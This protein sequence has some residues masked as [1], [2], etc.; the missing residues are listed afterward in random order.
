MILNDKKLIY[1][2]RVDKLIK[3]KK[4]LYENIDISEPM[5][6]KEKQLNTLISNLFSEINLIILEKRKLKA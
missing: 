1:I 3:L 2:N 6:K 5:S 4:C